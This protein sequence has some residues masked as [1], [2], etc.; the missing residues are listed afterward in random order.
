MDPSL[1]LLDL[2]LDFGLAWR[3]CFR[4]D[5]RWLDWSLSLLLASAFWVEHEIVSN[6]R[7]K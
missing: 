5:V 2:G 6:K 7:K 4:D 1:F 3:G